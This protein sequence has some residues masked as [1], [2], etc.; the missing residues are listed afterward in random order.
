MS[1]KPDGGPAFPQD[2]SMSFFDGEPVNCP[3]MEGH[4]GMTLRDYFAGQVLSGAMN[5]PLNSERFGPDDLPK[6]IK[7]ISEMCYQ[8]ADA[9]IAAREE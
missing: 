6:A 3:E 7:A 5:S 9:M 1:N 2:I 8:V 4:A